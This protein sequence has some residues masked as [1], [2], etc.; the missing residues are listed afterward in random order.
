MGFDKKRRGFSAFAQF[1]NCF[2]ALFEQL[3]IAF[4]SS[5]VPLLW[6]TVSHRHIS[7]VVRRVFVLLNDLK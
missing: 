4:I 2:V 5:F 7:L 1:K 6:Y 3:P